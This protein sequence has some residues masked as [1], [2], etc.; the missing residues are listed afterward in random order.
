VKV[1]AGPCR[2][3]LVP[4]VAGANWC[5]CPS[6]KTSIAEKLQET[7]YTDLII[8]SK[9]EFNH[10]KIRSKIFLGVSP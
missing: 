5:R 2:S 10:I 1:A 9:K 3:V 7:L 4:V 6:E 8:Y